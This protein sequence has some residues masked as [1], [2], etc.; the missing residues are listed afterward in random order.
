MRFRQAAEAH[1]RA[2]SL[3]AECPQNLQ[4]SFGLDE[5]RTDPRHEDEGLTDK[6]ARRIFGD[7]VFPM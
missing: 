4:H 1:E 5:K 3:Q 2:R 6:E 7:T